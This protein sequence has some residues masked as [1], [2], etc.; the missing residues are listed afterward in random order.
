MPPYF[1]NLL[2]W[3]AFLRT[4]L[5]EGVNKGDAGG[6][7][8]LM[9]EHSLDREPVDLA[10]PQFDVTGIEAEGLHA[11]VMEERFFGGALAVSRCI[12][13]GVSGPFDP[14]P[15]VDLTALIDEALKARFG[16]RAT[17]TSARS[18][19]VHLL[20]THSLL[21]AQKLF[22]HKS[23]RFAFTLNELQLTMLGRGTIEFKSLMSYFHQLSEWARER[24]K[25]EED[26]ELRQFSDQISDLAS[27][28]AVMMLMRG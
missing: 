4:L 13:K 2:L 25:A 6:V 8:Q 23:V 14:E 18:Y 20:S 9:S 10:G 16:E 28:L 24:L 19:V 3:L 12:S 22:D 27:F 7:V 21:R 17:V 11:F 1:T 15:G 5:L 26:A